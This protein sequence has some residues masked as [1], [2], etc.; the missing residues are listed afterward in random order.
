MRKIL[1]SNERVVLITKVM[2][3]SG[4]PLI[5]CQTLAQY[6]LML[7]LKILLLTKALTLASAGFATLG[8]I[9]GFYAAYL[10][11]VAST[12]TINP[13]WS[14]G[15]TASSVEPGEHEP[16]QDAWTGGIM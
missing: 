6:P 10:W 11:K 14:T 8:A 5:D 3:V 7:F 13:G 9:T 1:F 16:A 15:W 12:S 4:H 2:A